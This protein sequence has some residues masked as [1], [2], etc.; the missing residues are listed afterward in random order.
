MEKYQVGDRSFNSKSALNRWC[1]DQLNA[2]KFDE[3]VKDP[4]LVKFLFD[5]W[6]LH[7]NKAGTPEYFCVGRCNQNPNN[8]QFVAFL[9]G[10]KVEL[11][12][13]KYYPSI[14]GRVPDASKIHNSK[15]NDAL[16]QAVSLDVRKA[17]EVLFKKSAFCAV[18][19]E[20]LLLVKAHLDH[21]PVT[22]EELTDRFLEE[23]PISRDEIR[24]RDPGSEEH[25]Q[26]AGVRLCDSELAADWRRYHYANAFVRITACLPNLKRISTG[27][28][29]VPLAT[30]VEDPDAYK[31]FN[32]RTSG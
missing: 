32:P 6:E 9:G 1:K 23:R 29:G 20:A 5:A 28:I 22:F 18:S 2:H 15:V 21:H 27:K 8:K 13:T 17:K 10:R 26:E 11:K 12:P 14:T 19:G 31:L 24:F 25:G 16:R 7:P 4:E 30:V 3:R